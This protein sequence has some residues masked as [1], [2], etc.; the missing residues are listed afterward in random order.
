MSQ[1]ISFRPAD[2]LVPK[3][4]DLTKWTVVACDQ[5]TSQPEYW[6]RVDQ[7]VGD[8]PS[9]LRLILPES[10]LEGDSVAQDIAATNATMQTYLAN[11]QFT[12]YP[13]AMIYIERTQQNGKIRRGL[14][15]K[16]DLEE[17]DYTPG[18]NAQVRATEGTVLSRIPPRV[19]VRENAP[20]ELPHVMLLTDD[21]MKTVIEPLISKKS[22][23]T[24]I[25]DF[26]LM[27]N[28]GHITG[29]LLDG[30]AV[31]AVNS[32]LLALKVQDAEKFAQLGKPE[33]AGFLF[34]AGDG[35]H[36]LATAKTCY[37]NQKKLVP[38]SQWENLP[39]RFALCELVNLHDEA[40]DFEPIHRIV[41]GVRPNHLLNT[42][43]ARHPGSCEGEW[44]G[45]I[46]PYITNQL[47]SAITIANPT[48]QLEVGTLQHFLDAY[49]E[50]FGGNIDYIHGADVTRQLAQQEG[51]IG[52]LLPPM[53]KSS[54]YPTVIYDGVL[55]RKTF[56]MGEAHDKRFYLEAR[57]I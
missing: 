15:G 52:F 44:T 10:K 6:A 16:V 2:I 37:E 14:V 3:N 42:L 1:P 9:S 49:L 30:D 11:D 29:W 19:K 20:I 54:L 18:S 27:E 56:S 50:E 35:N 51:A 57:K 25:Y 39:S 34:A 26:D 24:Q 33:L 12:S 45:H 13:N 43:V 8:A 32:A 31:A 36:S 41:T 21:P 28:S 4:C 5:Y 48:A 53:A 40:L 17:Y 55:P 46:L 22:E 7:F 47:E 23:L 38:E